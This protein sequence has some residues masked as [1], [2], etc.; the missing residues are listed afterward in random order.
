[1]WCIFGPRKAREAN[2]LLRPCSN[3]AQCAAEFVR[4][5]NPLLEETG[6][7]H[8]QVASSIEQHPQG[9]EQALRRLQEGRR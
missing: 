4:L 8:R 5:F 7:G 9:R 6:H 2:D 3:F 1:V